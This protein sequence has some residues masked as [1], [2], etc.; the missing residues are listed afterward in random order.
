MAH[1]PDSLPTDNPEVRSYLEHLVAA[2]V[3]GIVLMSITAIWAWNTYGKKLSEA[4]PL[5]SGTPPISSAP[6]TTR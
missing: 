1:E 4:P 6:I 2:I 3:F 5:P